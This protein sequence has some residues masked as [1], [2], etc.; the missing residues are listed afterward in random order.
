MKRRLRVIKNC[1]IYSRVST[2]AQTEGYSLEA[3]QEVIREYAAYR[4]LKI[5]GDYC[6]AGKSGKNIK[7]RPAFRQMM[8]DIITQKDEVSFVLVYKLSR[9]GRNAADILRSI[10]TL[11]DYGIDLV[12]VNESIDS[13]TQGGR[14]TLAILSA[15]AEMERENITV[16]FMSGKL[17][18]AMN[19]GWSGGSIPYGYRNIDHKLVPDAYEAEV[20]R[21]VFE[22]YGQD[23]STASSVANALNESKYLRRDMQNEGTRPFTYDFVARVLDN[24]FYCGRICYNRRT[25]KKDH[26]GKTIKCD[27]TSVITVPGDHEALVTEEVWD[28]VHDKR[29]RLAERYKKSVPKATTY[30]LT[31]LLKCPICGGNLTGSFSKA[32]NL[33]GD[34]YYRTIYYYSCRNNTRQN[35]R[36]CSFSRRLNTEIVDGLV[37]HIISNLQ[38]YSEFKEAMKTAIGDLGSVEAIENKLKGLRSNL[39]DAE[40]SKNRLGEKLDGLNPLKADYDKKYSQVSDKLDEAYDR[41][42]ELENEI[43]ETRER[44]ASLN[45]KSDSRMQVNDYLDKVRH[46]LSKMSPEEKKEL[47]SSFIE[48]IDIFPEERPDGR[49][50]KS[51]SF[52]FPLAFNGKEMKGT[53]SGSG[54]IS[55]ELDCSG[56]DIELPEKGGI[57]MKSMPDGSRKAIVRKATYKA[58]R[59]FVFEKFG[60]HVSTL[61]IAQIK[62]KHG[63]EIGTAYNKPAEPKLR[64]PHCTQEKE[65]MILEAL[66]YY[67]VLD[68]KTE[69][70]EDE[71]P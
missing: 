17:Q 8:E 1:Y 44:L 35:G 66:K 60:V 14:L 43:E 68:Q 22:L 49:I 36:T 58:L 59:E 45:R 50:I 24:P 30:V 23:E 13:S 25:N 62:R 10:Q 65:K 46:M 16:Q 28:R 20:I 31:G 39:R 19:G 48:R 61:N 2:A 12:S 40:I 57:V 32:K 70:K 33:A 27:P 42:D 3:Q 71:K 37:F 54:T 55:F 38:V 53:A 69:Y 64:I 29:T 18:K 52:R 5:V 4:E 7:G 34:G 41:I 26:N 11:T 21:K 6:D 47:C 63:L 51:I 67:D 15:V 9:F 56:I